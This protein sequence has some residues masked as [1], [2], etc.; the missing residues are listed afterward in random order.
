M[1]NTDDQQRDDQPGDPEQYVEPQPRYTRREVELQEFAPSEVRIR[2]A[3]KLPVFLI[4]G[5]GLGAIVTFIATAIYPVDPQVG[6]GALFGYFSL[7]GVT[8][9]VVVGAIAAFIF[10]RRADRQAT[11]VS[12]VRESAEIVDADPAPSPPA[13]DA[14]PIAADVDEE[15][16]ATPPRT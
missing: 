13:P 11:T 8:G 7:Y 9:G 10:D 12:A 14:A 15:P 5:G 4:T 6:F 3:P 1:S 2:R 16:E